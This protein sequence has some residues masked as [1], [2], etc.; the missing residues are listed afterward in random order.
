MRIMQSPDLAL[1][2]DDV[3]LIPIHSRVLPHQVSLRTRLSRGI[4]LN[5]PVISA[6]M[7]TVTEARLAISLAQMGGI[8]IIHKNM[9]ALEQARQVR[10]VK[11]YESGVIRQP[12]TVG[13]DAT[14]REV[15]EL[16]QKLK[17]S[18]VP[19][20]DGQVL[21]GIV[22]SRDFRFVNAMDAPVSSIMT[23]RER[24]VT[25][26]D[27][28]DKDAI[29]A[30][31]HEHRIEKV[32][33]VDDEFHLKGL[34]TVKDIQKAKEYPDSC[35]DDHECLRVGAAIG[36]GK[37][38]LARA[39]ALFDAGVDALV[40]D[41][42]HG[43]SK[44]VLEMIGSLKKMY[45]DLQVIGGNIATGAAASALLEAGVD[46]VKVGMGP[47]SICTT[48]VISGVGVPQFTAIANVAHALKGTGLPIIADGG[49]RYSGDIAKALAIGADSVM[50]GS[51][52][53]GAEEAPGELELYQGRTYKSYRG[54]GSLGAMAQK[55]GSSDRYFQQSSEVDKLV[56]EGIEGRV[57]YRGSLNT[58]I[59]QLSG[60]VRAALGYTGSMDLSEFRSNAHFVR[61][62]GAG[63]RE[64]HAHDVVIT[65]EPPNYFQA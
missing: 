41:T 31:L 39:E 35:L 6:A 48:R 64:G 33:V 40:V 61:I 42:A 8:G 63:Y 5:L 10:E 3:L 65:K 32:L 9:D 1:T 57:P 15:F 43:D 7:D 50:I 45:P 14:I 17:F 46:A 36:V 54:M 13:P 18:G 38:S 60:G 22:T 49:I 23:P 20:M 12:V 53:A 56:P 37:G 19:V 25:V 26:C 2:F 4:S 11:K 28:T 44:D 51:M 29:R 62:T 24:L 55:H 16:T 21:V 58:I 34:V 30:L 47:G 27:E 52:F 59:T